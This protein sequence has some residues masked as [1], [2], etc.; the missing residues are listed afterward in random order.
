MKKIRILF[1]VLSLII[2]TGCFNQNNGKQTT[3]EMYEVKFLDESNHVI[4]T[5]NVE[6]G[7]NASEPVAPEKEGYDFIGWDKVLTNIKSDLIVK[8][9]Y[10]IK[11]FKVT[12]MLD[13]TIYREINV[14]Y[15]NKVSI[16]QVPT[17][18]DSE[19]E[20]WYINNTYQNLFNFDVKVK[21]N[22]VVYGKWKDFTIQDFLE[23]LDLS[24]LFFGK[25]YN[26]NYYK[27]TEK[28][29][30]KIK[31]KIDNDKYL[32]LLDDNQIL[33]H[34]KGFGYLIVLDS[35]TNEELKYVEYSVKN[36]ALTTEIRE[37]LIRS[38]VID[39]KAANFSYDEAIQTK[40][41]TLN[42]RLNDIKEMASYIQILANLEYL[43]LKNNDLEDI[44]FLENL[45]KLKYI[46]LSH[47]N[48]STL[49]SFIG[50]TQL[51][52]LNLS[53]NKIENLNKLSSNSLVQTLE[54]LDLR[55]NLIGNVDYL[56]VYGNNRALTTLYLGKNNI[57]SVS[58][59]A[60]VNS[61][62]NLDLSYTNVDVNTVI[63]FDYFR[64]L[65]HLNLSGMA[66]SL[67]SLP[68][69]AN[70]EELIISNISKDGVKMD[71]SALLK[72]KT[73]K[74][75]DISNNELDVLDI[76]Y[77]TK[78]YNG[79]ALDNLE[80]L[81]ISGNRILDIPDFTLLTKLI[82]LKVNNSRNLLTLSNL[83]TAPY[84]KLLEL[85][86]N[87]L[88]ESYNDNNPNNLDVILKQLPYLEKLNIVNSIQ[89]L[90][91]NSY[92]YIF[93]KV[94]NGEL[95]FKLFD[96]KWLDKINIQYFDT[97][98][99]FSLD[100]LKEDL[101][102]S[103]SGLTLPTSNTNR[104]IIINL[105]ND[106]WSKNIIEDLTINIPKEIYTITLI[107]YH[108]RTWNGFNIHVLDRKTLD[109]HIKLYNFNF[110]A[111]SDEYAILSTG[112]N[113]LYISSYGKKNAIIGGDGS[114]G[115]DGKAAIEARN[116]IINGLNNLIIQGGNGS[117]GSDEN[118]GGNGG[119]A[120]KTN[121]LELNG[122]VTIYGGH[123]GVGG[124][125]I[126]GKK[127]NDGK[128][129]NAQGFRGE[130]G[131]NGASGT[132]GGAGG[133]GAVAIDATNI[134][135]NGK[136]IIIGGN[137][138]D[139]GK[140]GTGGAGGNGGKSGNDW[141]VFSK[142]GLTGGNA[143]HGGAGG[144]GGD[145][146]AN[147]Q[148]IKATTIKLNSEIIVQAGKLGKAGEGGAGG[149]GGTGGDSGGEGA[150]GGSGGNGGTGGNAGITYC[151][152]SAFSISEQFDTSKIKVNDYISNT[153]ALGGKGGAA[154]TAG[155]NSKTG[156]VTTW[157]NGS[158]GKDG[159]KSNF[160]N[161]N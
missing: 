70:L 2:L 66:L 121:N 34:G 56:S 113:N 96:D 55:N 46:D 38:N 102:V 120:I 60:G 111:S 153:L 42:N 24:N 95:E 127:G 62:I 12:F 99:Y 156:E 134:T 122:E 118:K 10:K 7:S 130:T 136:A 133:N 23:Q 107:G 87:L 79:S 112:E 26:L 53:Y 86:N 97:K 148:A 68:D 27:L 128:G 129:D 48:I 49:P 32:D 8:P 106:M 67:N 51:T 13:N 11:T 85:E 126:A 5:Q 69:M 40:S 33:V 145:S 18:V 47:N 45:K 125:G 143:G 151:V 77:I 75:L 22:T 50:F 109:L 37:E 146:G 61:I 116:V 115:L 59:L 161:V 108:E 54:T 6:K 103:D 110:K 3:K 64:D 19:F 147:G 91:R 123:G 88:L 44:K 63:A 101:S 58:S 139:G 31:I 21:E 28:D 138:G 39:S 141:N 150:D 78:K 144:T 9:I 100:E 159:A 35:K 83:S 155:K 131:E 94:K 89:L 41:L 105:V 152:K 17:K 20:E 30:D 72:Y 98:F 149:A 142:W 1:V 124:N 119:S 158:I 57:T 43:D 93:N 29:K 36:D 74:V 80:E 137:G 4:N 117:N 15:G 157:K 16:P 160:L 14:E 82:S 65:H 76:D 25:K 132:T 92:D 104:N 154:G 84:L 73:L 81:D 135:F 71:T 140:G 52:Y 114:T 90:S